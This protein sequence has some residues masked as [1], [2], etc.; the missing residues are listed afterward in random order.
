MN[1]HPLLEHPLLQHLARVLAGRPGAV[2]EDDGA[3]AR[4]AVALALR[5][6]PEG[7]PEILLI[8]RATREGD[9]WSGQ[10]ALPG[11]RWSP[12][13]ESL[14]ATAY[15]ETVEETGLDLDVDG[16]VLGV[17]DEL[18]PRTPALPPIIV[19]PF[20]VLT[21]GAA[22]LVLNHEVAAAFWMP[23]RH[24]QDPEVARESHV[25]VRGATWRVPSFVFGEYV[26]WG[27]TE[28]ILRQLL[29]LLP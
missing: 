29:E 19:T 2:A 12:N 7:E 10:V 16:L 4:A 21:A 24:L 8:R 17:L 14:Q 23:L 9:P 13:D 15:R 28:R 25:Q 5:L 27:M 6:G 18:R 22:S 20:V 1:S 11:G 26:V 3:P